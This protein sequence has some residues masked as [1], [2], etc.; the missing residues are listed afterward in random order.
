VSRDDVGRCLAALALA[1]PTGRAD[2]ITGPAALD[3]TALA[4]VAAANWNVPVEYVELTP[5]DY[6]AETAAA[7]ED[8]WWL[9]AYS[10]MSASI[11]QHRWTEVT[12]DVRRLTGR[13]PLSVAAVL[14]P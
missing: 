2:A 5:H 6:A 1:G 4:A 7:G 10:S 11:R 13:P 12:D 14:P 9:Y 3:L 8:P